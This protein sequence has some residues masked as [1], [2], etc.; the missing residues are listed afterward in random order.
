[1]RS[2][3]SCP[4]L[5]HINLKIARAFSREADLN[6]SQAFAGTEAVLKNAAFWGAPLQLNLNKLS[7]WAPKDALSLE[8]GA[9]GLKD[10]GCPT[11]AEINF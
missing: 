4:Q 5:L 6:L 8:S 2:G 7:A 3:D 11:K 9:G 1:M 10:S